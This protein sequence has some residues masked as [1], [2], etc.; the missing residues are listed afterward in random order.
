MEKEVWKDIKGYEGLYQ[1]SNLGNIKSLNKVQKLYINNAKSGIRKG[2]QLKLI[3]FNNGYYFV[4]LSKNG[5]IH[6]YAVHR[7]VAKTFISNPN[8]LP[9]INHIDGNKLN[10]NINNLEWCTYSHN[11]QEAFRLGLSKPIWKGKFDKNH[12]RSKKIIQYDLNGNVIKE[13]NSIAEASRQLNIEQKNISACCRKKIKTF[14]KF[15]WRF[16]D[17]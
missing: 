10:N 12:N 3:L 5:K 6:S 11:I 17:E 2:K 13:W 15:I 7:L 14:K 4:N 1:I 16:K 9:I 8:N